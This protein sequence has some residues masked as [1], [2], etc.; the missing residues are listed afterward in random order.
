[1]R[2]IDK[3][4]YFSVGHCHITLKGSV[5]FLEKKKRKENY[6]Y[7]RPEN[8]RE[9]NG[10]GDQEPGVTLVRMGGTC[11]YCDLPQAS[12][13]LSPILSFPFYQRFV[14]PCKTDLFNFFEIKREEEEEE[15]KE[16]TFKNSSGPTYSEG[17]SLKCLRV[18]SPAHLLTDQYQNNILVS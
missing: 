5:R 9:G 10:A 6:E 2:A 13:Y 16:N 7:Q 12:G 14:M 3:K 1:M 15:E 8:L 4:L 17:R 18:R 11:Q